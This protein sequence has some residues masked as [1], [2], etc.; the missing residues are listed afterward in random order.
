[1]A[2]V[3]GW[4]DFRRKI[5]FECEYPWNVFIFYVKVPK[6]E[7]KVFGPSDLLKNGHAFPSQALY[8]VYMQYKVPKKIF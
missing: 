7:K 4:V 3:L 5:D 2:T 1:M 6:T 8:K